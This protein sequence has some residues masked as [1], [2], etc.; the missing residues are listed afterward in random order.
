MLEMGTE[1][2]TVQDRDAGMNNRK[3]MIRKAQLIWHKKLLRWN[4]NFMGDVWKVV[5][6]EVAE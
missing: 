4:K 1:V 3:R 5:Y 2:A 6:C